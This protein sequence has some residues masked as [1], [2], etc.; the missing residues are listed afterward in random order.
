MTAMSDN[1]RRQSPMNDNGT[2]ST[3]LPNP[4]EFYLRTDG[5]VHGWFELGYCSYVV[6]PR[7]VLQCLPLAVQQR[8]VDVLDEV[9]EIAGSELLGHDYRVSVLGKRGRFVRN[10]LPAYRHGS[11]LIPEVPARYAVRVR[12]KE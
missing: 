7:V 3:K 10:P 11:D 2:E 6:L 5:P 8:L 1:G 9:A 4:D 12:T